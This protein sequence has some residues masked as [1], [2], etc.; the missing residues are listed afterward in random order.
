MVPEI[1]Y[2]PMLILATAAT[3]IASQA[4]ITGAFS[5]TQQAVQLGLLPRID[6]RNTS[7]TQAGQIFVPAVNTFLMIGVLLLLVVFQ[8]SHNLTAAYGVAVTGTMLVNTLMSYSVI[9][10]GW[11]WPMWRSPEP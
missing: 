7:E 11:K 2:W 4:V 10:K 9:T 3:V 1:A 8:S 6:I 5:V